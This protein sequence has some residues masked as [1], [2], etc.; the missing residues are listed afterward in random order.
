MGFFKALGSLFG[1]FASKSNTGRQGS[2][3]RPVEEPPLDISEILDT[4]ENRFLAMGERIYVNSSN[5]AWIQYLAAF[6]G[7]P[8]HLYVGYLDGSAYGYSEITPEMAIAFLNAPSKGKWVWDNLRIR[9]TVF[10]WQKP[11]AFLNA[12]SGEAT[13]KWH[14]AGQ[15]SQARH[16]AIPKHGE[17]FRG[18]HPADNFH[19]AKGPLGPNG[20]EGGPN[21]N[22]NKRRRKGKSPFRN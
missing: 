21:P 3:G 11:Y 20:S 22:F 14:E 15:S 8:E 6:E 19:V 1:F 10:G 2:L 16:A 9:G 12:A 17:P 13:R 5:V 7:T 4:E 18:Y